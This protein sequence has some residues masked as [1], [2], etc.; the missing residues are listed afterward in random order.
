MGLLLGNLLAVL[1]WTFICSPIAV[2]TRLTLY[3]YLRKVIGPGPLL[4]YNTVNGI[5]YCALG[6]AMI[7][8]AASAVRIP[9]GIEEQTKWYPEDLRF[10]MELASAGCLVA[11]CDGRHPL[12]VAR[13]DSRI[14]SNHSRLA[15]GFRTLLSPCPRSGRSR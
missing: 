3:W 2:K 15:G 7:T 4:I 6:G 13:A 1:S 9:F 10:V 12:L 14:L 8:V 11:S 5:M